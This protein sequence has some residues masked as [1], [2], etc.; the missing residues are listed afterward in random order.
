MISQDLLFSDNCPQPDLSPSSPGI[1]AHYNWLHSGG[2]VL[3]DV[4][5]SG[6]TIWLH[7]SIDQDT[8]FVAYFSSQPGRTWFSNETDY[9]TALST[10]SAVIFEEFI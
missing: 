4:L 1:C 8:Y 7:K 10:Y 6:A 5:P 9:E 2:G 3:R